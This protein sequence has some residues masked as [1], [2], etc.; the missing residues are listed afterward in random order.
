MRFS[1]Q[2]FAMKSRRPSERRE[3]NKRGGLKRSQLGLPV[4]VARCVD[5]RERSLDSSC[6]FERTLE[7]FVPEPI[8]ETVIDLD[9]RNEPEQRAPGRYS[10][11]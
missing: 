4:L 2:P 7:V 3:V 8:V 10:A 6:M 11:R 1:Q 5:R 9:H